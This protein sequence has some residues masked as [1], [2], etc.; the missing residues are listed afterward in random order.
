M[1]VFTIEGG[2]PLNGDVSVQ[3]A[4]NSVLPILSACVLARGESVI[5]NCPR[6]T[7]VDCAM[8][9]LRSLGCKC[10]LEGNTLTADS[11]LAD[12]FDVSDEL[13]C[14]MRSSVIFLGAL[15]ARFGRAEISVPGGC[16]LGIRPINLHIDALRKMGATIREEHGRISCRVDG[17][18]KGCAIDLPI[19]S[20]GATENIVIAA[21]TAEGTTVVRNAAKEPEIVDLV[22]FLR[23]CG[24]HIGGE[25]STNITVYGV[26]SLHAAE[27][28]VIPDRIAA[29]TYLCAAAACSGEVRLLSAT[30][31]HLS[32]MLSCFEQMGCKVRTGGGE[33]VL[34]SRGR[35]HRISDV[36]THE[37][38][39]FP[40]DAQPVMLA[41][42]AKARGTSVFV[43]NIFSNRYRFVE[44]LTK[45][46]ASIKVI[47]R[48]AVVEGVERLFSADVEATDL[49][50]GAAL[51]IAAM[52]ADGVSHISHLSHIDRGY[53]APEA[54]LLSL[55]AH[56]KRE[57]I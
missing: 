4:K 41:T 50:G 35:L 26:D 10:R 7:D 23:S 45:M 48:V 55:G 44:G 29:T 47:D 34:T 52:A 9:I 24:A 13:M 31:E 49:R 36:S 1:S 54:V 20:V 51:M 17:R 12:R 30:E 18:L 19:A 27:H 40:T 38:P 11:T 15:L 28:T 57:D 16:E 5:H 39:G 32:P 25:G 46:G 21:A 14:S 6:L 53:E 43:E 56:I 33:I 42:V 37:Y 3:G 2:Y 22:R 8:R